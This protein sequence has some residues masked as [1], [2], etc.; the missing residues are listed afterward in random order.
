MNELQ[1]KNYIYIYI[2]INVIYIGTYMLH[3]MQ[4]WFS[5]A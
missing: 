3:K 4:L 2:Y 5:D 1:F